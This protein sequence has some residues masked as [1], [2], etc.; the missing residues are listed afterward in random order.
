[1]SDF[2]DRK[3]HLG[4]FDDLLKFE[5]NVRIL[6]VQD[7]PGMGKT[8]FLKRLDMHCKTMTPGIPSALVDFRQ[9]EDR[10]PFGLLYSVWKELKDRDVLFPRFEEFFNSFDSNNNVSVNMSIQNNVFDNVE[11]INVSSVIGDMVSTLNAQP[12]SSNK[13][14]KKDENT[15][16]QSFLSDMQHYCNDQ[17]IVILFDHYESCFD[18]KLKKW[19]VG[20]FLQRYFFNVSNRPQKLLLV[21]AGRKDCLPSFDDYWSPA[22]HKDIVHWIDKL[23][24][25]PRGE[26]KRFIKLCKASVELNEIE[27]IYGLMKTGLLDIKTLSDLVKSRSNQMMP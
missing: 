11:H 18:E 26:L 27:Q 4:C 7:K 23:G 14:F 17:P 13:Q 1:M 21:I 15:A 25:W 5:S 8:Y 19:V 3:D 9:L 12:I 16:E 24:P 22:I 10:S 2:V 20:H 6:V